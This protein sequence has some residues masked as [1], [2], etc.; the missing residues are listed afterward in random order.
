MTSQLDTTHEITVE[1]QKPKTALQSTGMMRSI[2]EVL[3]ALQLDNPQ[4][5]TDKKPLAFV[6]AQ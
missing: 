4:R 1:Q 6:N 3:Q 2:P 5:K